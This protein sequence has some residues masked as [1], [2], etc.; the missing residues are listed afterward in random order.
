MNAI[1]WIGVIVMSSLLAQRLCLGGVARAKTWGCG[2]V[3]PAPRMQYTAASLSELMAARML[4]RCLRPR[5]ATCE[6]CDL[7][8]AS[9]SF[10]SSCPDPVTRDVYEPFFVRWSGRFAALR[11]LQQGKMHFYL[12]YIMAIVMMGLSWVALRNWLSMS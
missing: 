7:F 9:S 6:P 1:V 2:Y 3:A 10:S 12:V 4:P 8:P 5:V 11:I